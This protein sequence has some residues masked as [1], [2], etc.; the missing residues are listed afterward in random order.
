MSDNTES[1]S[2]SFDGAELTL[3]RQILVLALECR[4]P[5]NPSIALMVDDFDRVEFRRNAERRFAPAPGDPRCLVVA[6]DDSRM[7]KPHARAMRDGASWV[8]EDLGSSN[9]SFIGTDRVSRAEL[10]PGAFFRLGHTF[11][12]WAQHVMPVSR[13]RHYARAVAQGV[14]PRFGEVATLNAPYAAV[15]GDLQRIAASSIPVLL[16]G[17]T[18]TGK[19]LLARAVHDASGRRGSF[20]AVNCGAIPLGL[21]SA[22]LFGHKRGAFTGAVD[23]EPG[24]FR[25]ADAGTL[26]LDE[27]AELPADVQAT[28]LRV[29]QTG[30]VAVVGSSK[31]VQVDVR[32][33]SASHQRLDVLVGAGSFRQDLCARLEGFVFETVPPRARREDLGLLVSETLVSLGQES[34]KIRPELGL[35]LLNH[36]WPMN[37]RELRQ[38][39]SAASVLAEEGVLTLAS[40]PRARSPRIEA[41]EGRRTTAG[42]N[43]ASESLSEEDRKLRATLVATLRTHD[44]NVTAAARDMGKARQQLQRWVKR[45]GIEREELED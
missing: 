28:L 42:S 32:V 17:E 15:L 35:A 41:N 33:V 29:L 1:T 16:Q 45:L 40:F 4:A 34:L 9:G 2:R 22:Q 43:D 10:R 25:A 27:V 38:R 36:D 5:T 18:G 37:V 23:A 30:E 8:L 21:A 7:S 39:L 24:F 3:E 20:V 26:F 12:Y 11:F 14:A 44:G 31:P 6:V 13:W 19:E